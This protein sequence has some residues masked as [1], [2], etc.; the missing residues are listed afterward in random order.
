LA[1][2]YMWVMRTSGGDAITCCLLSDG[3]VGSL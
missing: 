3:N 1:V 2:S